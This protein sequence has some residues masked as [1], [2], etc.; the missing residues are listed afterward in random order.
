MVFKNC[1]KIFLIGCLL[2]LGYSAVSAQSLEP[3]CKDGFYEIPNEPV[4]SRAPKCD[5]YN[6]D[7]TAELPYPNPQACMGDGDNRF[8]CDGWV[9]LCCYEVARTGD[10]TKCVGYWERLWCSPYQC[11]TARSNGAS[12]DQCGG[13]CLCGHAF[14][15]YCGK[16][17][18]LP[19]ED[20]LSGKYKYGTRLNLA[21]PTPTAVPTPNPTAP[22]TPTPTPTLVSFPT[23]PTGTTTIVPEPTK[24]FYNINSTPTMAVPKNNFVSPTPTEKKLPE[25][26]FPKWF[27]GEEDKEPATTPI[28]TPTVVNPTQGVKKSFRQYLQERRAK[29]AFEIKVDYKTVAPIDSGINK[30]QEVKKEVLSLDKKISNTIDN[31]FKDLFNNLL[32]NKIVL[33]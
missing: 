20:R 14:K 3:Y 4:C 17:P 31:F 9:P 27:F 21:T 5:G 30:T 32:H 13:S 15:S 19:L 16:R 11:D 22:Q 23:Y 8:G 29:V 28:A 18:P 2:F 7:E 6:Y 10:F 26:F 12:D 25:E 33:F 1:L 24:V